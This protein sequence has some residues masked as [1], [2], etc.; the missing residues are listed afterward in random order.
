MC[1]QFVLCYIPSTTSLLEWI[2]IILIF[3]FEIRLPTYMMSFLKTYLHFERKHL[4]NPRTLKWYEI[5]MLILLSLHGRFRSL[6][7]LFSH[8][9]SGV[10]NEKP[11]RR[12]DKYSLH[13]IS[14][15]TALAGPRLTLEL[16]AFSWKLLRSVLGCNKTHHRLI[17]NLSGAEKGLPSFLI[18]TTRILEWH[19]L[20]C[21]S[22]GK[23]LHAG[24][25]SG[26]ICILN[27]Q[28]SQGA[29]LA[30]GPTTV[31]L[32]RSKMLEMGHFLS[33]FGKVNLGDSLAWKISRHAQTGC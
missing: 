9:A 12:P 11:Q 20:D 2:F 31:E 18:P 4:S 16:T 28:V 27:L 15:R 17:K 7:S 26:K 10:P 3:H 14:L 23:M 1:L 25:N 30:V 6:T 33:G 21:S 19:F 13:Q 24:S 5:A 22:L 8:P 32:Q 29:H